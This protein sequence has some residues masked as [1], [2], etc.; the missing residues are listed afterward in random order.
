MTAEQI[1][2]ALD[3]VPFRAFVMHLP[4]GRTAAVPHRDF[5]SIHPNG[6][7]VVIHDEKGGSRIFD[8]LLVTELKF[9]EAAA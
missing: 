3:Q 2:K 5:V 1:K 8:T 6:R 7:T 4:K 9:K